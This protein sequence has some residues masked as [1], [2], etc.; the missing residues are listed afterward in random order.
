MEAY[1]DAIR[2]TA[3]D[4][5]P[6]HVIPADHKWFTRVVVAAVVI[7]SLASLDL[8]YPRL[9]EDKRRELVAARKALLQG[10]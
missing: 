4:E 7:E 8:A 2:H 3:T 9:N 10:T 1:E 5:A 6:W